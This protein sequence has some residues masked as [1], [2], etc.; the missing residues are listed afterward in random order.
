MSEL[1]HTA[2]IETLER[3]QREMTAA[4][5]RANAQIALNQEKLEQLDRTNEALAR[6]Q[7]EML[8]QIRNLLESGRT[9]DALRYVV[10]LCDSAARPQ[11]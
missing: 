11:H 10:A 8:R 7:M 9:S 3:L 2:C 4:M 5:D 6:T 1:D